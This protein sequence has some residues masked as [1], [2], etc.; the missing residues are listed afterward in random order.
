MKKKIES[1]K[2]KKCEGI[3]LRNN[4]YKPLERQEV[5]KECLSKEFMFQYR[6]MFDC[7]FGETIEWMCKEYNLPFVYELIYYHE[8]ISNINDK[9]ESYINDISL[10]PMYQD[11]SDI[12]EKSDIEFINDD[13]KQLKKNIE[14][15]IQKEDFNAHNKWMNCLRDALELREKLQGNNNNTFNI[16]IGDI[17]NIDFDKVMKEIISKSK[18]T[19]NKQDIDNVDYI[20]ECI[21]RSLNDNYEIAYGQKSSDKPVFMKITDRRNKEEIGIVINKNS[22]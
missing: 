19:I 17:K 2:C 20:S 8:D 10:L 1:I 18:E 11:S 12:K 16:T 4:F 6:A 22:N 3:Q 13:I 21:L 9:L 14:K 5:C 7:D 15:A